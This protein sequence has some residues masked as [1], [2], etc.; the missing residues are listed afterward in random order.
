MIQLATQ[1]MTLQAKMPPEAILAYHAGGIAN[2]CV[3]E[4]S[5]SEFANSAFSVSQNSKWGWD[6]PVSKTRHELFLSRDESA[7]NRAIG[8]A[9]HILWDSAYKHILSKNCPAG[10]TLR[11]FKP[12]GELNL[13]ES[14]RAFTL[15]QIEFAHDEK[16]FRVV[17]RKNDTFFPEYIDTACIDAVIQ[18]CFPN[19]ILSI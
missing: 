2:S 19:G 13:V 8:A 4:F 6:D 7:E 17:P 5:S 1:V 15:V 11:T 9:L 14:G 12:H 3:I 16:S 18:E 10:A